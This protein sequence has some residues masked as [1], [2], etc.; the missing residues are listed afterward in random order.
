MALTTCPECEGTLSSEAKA[1]PHCGSP[2]RHSTPGMPSSPQYRP[3]QLNTRFPVL[4]TVALIIK[5]LGW[6]ITTCSVLYIVGAVLIEPNQSGHRYGPED[7]MQLAGGLCVAVF[8]LTQVALAEI[9]RVF[10]AI[11][12]HTASAAAS[13]SEIPSMM[14][15]AG[16]GGPVASDSVPT[17]NRTRPVAV[18]NAQ[19]IATAHADASRSAGN[20]GSRRCPKCGKEWEYGDECPDCGIA[21]QQ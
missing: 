3:S 2:S 6:L 10:F 8:G 4:T 20:A 18:W 21:L 9:I 11:E 5:I 7:Y 15:Q 12:Q 1:C 19:P 17:T 16:S 14:T 13:L